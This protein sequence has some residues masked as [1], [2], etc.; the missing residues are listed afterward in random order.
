MLYLLPNVLDK[1]ADYQTM[2]PSSV[3]KAIASLDGLI[4][5]NEKQGRH[6]LSHFKIKMPIQKMPILVLSEHTKKD[7]IPFL[8][9]KIRMKD[10][11]TALE[12]LTVSFGLGAGIIIILTILAG[13]VGLLYKW[14]VLVYL[15]PCAVY[16]LRSGIDEAGRNR[17]KKR[18]F[19]FFEKYLVL[20][21]IAAVLVRLLDSLAP[22]TF[23]DSQYYHL[24]IPQYWIHNH[25]ISTVPY[26]WNSYFPLNFHILY[27][28][29]LLFRNDIAAKL[30]K[31]ATSIMRIYSLISPI[32]I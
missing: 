17:E 27:T 19:S 31:N 30:V 26:V 2:L 7:E 9:K 1:N 32:T 3:H 4:A 11:L 8:L 20:V 25:R 10:T 18:K 16:G 28:I 12:R 5:E 15:V 13:S 6:Y 22:E 24:T 29:C 21:F 14:T 23:Y